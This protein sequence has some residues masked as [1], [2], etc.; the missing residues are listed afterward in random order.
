DETSESRATD[1]EAPVPADA[2]GPPAVESSDSA[3][4]R[5]PE[6][7]TQPPTPSAST[8]DPNAKTAAELALYLPDGELALSQA[9]DVMKHGKR[10]EKARL[11]SLLLTYAGW[12]EIWAVADETEVRKLFPHLD[13]PD[14]LAAAWARHL[15]I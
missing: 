10:A 4:V 7:P 5:R 13:L 11:V 3:D 8:A 9:R 1:G 6:A 14:R 12:D 2:P 15:K